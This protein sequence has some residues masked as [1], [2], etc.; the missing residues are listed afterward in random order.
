MVTKR[1]VRHVTVSDLSGLQGAAV[2]RFSYRGRALEI[3]LT[4]PERATLR[5]L[6]QVYGSYGRRV[7]A[8][9]DRE[10]RQ[11][12]AAARAWGREHGWQVS[13]RGHVPKAL[14]AAYEAAQAEG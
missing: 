12:M 2:T 9:T 11:Y 13:D 10:R 3:D 5:S 14:L 4:S 8:G 6:V 1:I 7:P